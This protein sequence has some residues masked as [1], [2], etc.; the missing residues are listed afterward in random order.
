MLES[1]CDRVQAQSQPATYIASSIRLYDTPKSSNTKSPQCR[2]RS[3]RQDRDFRD[4]SRRLR[5]LEESTDSR[6]K[7]PLYAWT[8]YA[9]VT[10]VL[11]QAS[12]KMTRRVNNRTSTPRARE[13]GMAQYG[14]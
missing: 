6:Y 13:V 2:S 4:Q 5:N 10:Q 1:A 11:R 14:S 12:D 8:I 3:D 9:S 7:D